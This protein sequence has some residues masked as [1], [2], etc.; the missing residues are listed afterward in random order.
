VGEVALADARSPLVLTLDV[1]TSSARAM[2][3]DAA[4][5]AVAAAA[6]RGSVPLDTTPD[7][8]AEVDADAL[9]ACTAALLDRLAADAPAAVDG[10]RAVGA[11]TFWHSLLGVDAEGRAITPVLLWADARSHA[12]VRALRATLDERAVH[13]RTGCVLHWSYWPAKLRWLAETRPDVVRRAR[14]WLSFGEYLYLQLFGE[15]HNSVSMASGT[16]L[17]DQHTCD[18]DPMVLAAIPLDPDKLAPLSDAPLS[19][20][21][22]AYA[23]RW[24]ALRGVPWYPARGDGA[25]SNVGCGCVTCDRF[26]LMVG[27]SGALRVAWRAPEVAIPWGAWCY[28]V[29]AARFVM[30]GALNNGGNLFAWLDDTLRLEN[31]PALQA[32]V[33]ALPP[34]S[35]GLT[36]LPF[37]AGERSPGWASVARGA[38]V[39][40]TLATKPVD[41][42]RAGL[43]AVALRFALLAGILDA[44]VPGAQ[45]LIATGGALLRSP[46]W[47]QIIADAVGRPLTLS[48]EGEASSRGAALLALE[49]LGAIPSVEA[50][51]AELGAAFAPNP[52]HHARYQAALARQQ[53]LYDLLVGTDTA[54]GPPP[55]SC[56]LMLGE[57]E[58]ESPTG[59]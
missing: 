13:A 45:Q 9:V 54:A 11:A 53:R 7:G 34:D 18:W 56:S 28:R 10:V 37:L 50:V 39:G 22:P 3:Y 35:H 27:T 41:I 36:V 14:R 2:V 12:A 24:P 30:G 16:G 38:V 23:A 17:L 33:A 46:T 31:G 32:A 6:A 49:A 59:G 19:G 58:G 29:D 52:A 15:T 55:V 42:L 48:A 40:L 43:E 21:R 8:G 25:C 4:G 57:H 47:T 20:L 1:G 5:R 44:V 51:P 26:A